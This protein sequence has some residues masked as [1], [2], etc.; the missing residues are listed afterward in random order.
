MNRKKTIVVDY[1]DT[2]AD[3]TGYLCQL[4]NGLYN[5]L[6]SPS[7]FNNYKLPKELL[8]TFKEYENHGIYS[9]LKLLPDSR[10]ALRYA[11][12]IGYH[13]IIMTARKREYEKQTKMNIIYN[14]LPYDELLFV[15]SVRKAS[16]IK[17]LL[18]NY[19]ISLFADDKATTINRVDKMQ[20][21]D[22]V[23]LINKPH[24]MLDTF[25]SNVIRCNT[26]FDA[27][28]HLKELN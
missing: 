12:M 27:V 5:T 4:H 17:A 21:V 22:K 24:N 8:S 28:K 10:K 23:I 13:I 26:L 11:K 3:F 18:K 9:A 14:N 20:I 25:S 16:R 15:P 7:D 6:Y 1:D 19:D 2:I